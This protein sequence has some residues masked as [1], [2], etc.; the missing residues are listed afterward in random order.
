MN[1]YIVFTGIGFELIGLI[2]GSVYLGSFLES[3]YSLKG[4]WTAIFIII[5]MVAWIIHIV[6]MLKKVQ[7]KD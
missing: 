2:I 6:I 1:K 3:K 4:L 5:S 7:K